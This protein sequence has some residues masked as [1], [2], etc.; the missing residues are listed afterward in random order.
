[1]TVIL[2]SNRPIVDSNV[3][4]QLID[5]PESACYTEHNM[6]SEKVIHG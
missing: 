1:M 4:K 5:I 6:L 3:K 2:D